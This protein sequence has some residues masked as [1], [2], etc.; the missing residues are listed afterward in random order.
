M[1]FLARRKKR[2][3][4][5]GNHARTGILR[6]ESCSQAALSEISHAALRNLLRWTPSSLMLRSIGAGID[7]DVD[8]VPSESVVTQGESAIT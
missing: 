6:R 4:E 1:P 2:K 8:D 5:N 3:S 7:M